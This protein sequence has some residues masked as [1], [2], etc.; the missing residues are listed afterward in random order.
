MANSEDILLVFPGQF[1]VK[2]V[3]LP[4]SLLYVAH[5]L[6]NAGYSVRILD[7]RVENYKNFTWKDF[8]FVGITTMSGRQVY[9]GLEVAKFIKGRNPRQ[10]IIWGGPH[11]TI[12]PNEVIQS[13]Y[14]DIV[15]RGEGEET[16]LALAGRLASGKTYEDI[17]GLTFMEDEKIVSTKDTT[18]VDLNK[19]K[20]LPYFLLDIKSYPNNVEK[21]DYISSKG[22][23]HQCTFCSDAANYG[24]SWRMKSAE[25]VLEEFEYIINTFRPNRINIQD[26][27]FFVS[28]KRVERIC[29]GIL[30]RGWKIELYSFI[31]ADY[32]STYK[33]DFL[34]LIR[35]AGFKE[36]AFGAESGSD[37]LLDFIKKRETGEQILGAVRK[38]KKHGIKPVISLMI[39][40]PT[41]TKK[42]LESTLDLYDKIMDIYPEAMVNGLFI[43]TPFP[44]SSLAEFVVKEYGYKFPATL[45]DWGK[46]KWSSPGNITW[47]EKE[48][49]ERYEAIYLLV[50]FLFVYKL[51]GNWTFKQLKARCGS[52]ILASLVFLFNNFFYPFAKIRWENR[53]FKHPFE[54]RLW[55]LAYGRFKGVD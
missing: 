55:Y 18:P 20:H 22:C 16:L 54:W 26:A 15:V 5:P 11:P 10:K 51:L 27:N 21:F 39:G 7:C 23:P 48:A 8:L 33:D 4:L 46:W 47:V 32:V 29:E 24:R 45:E 25:T 42:E 49:R 50:R 12:I 37:R 34:E 9:E 14:S 28:K 35:S 36:V 19:Y 53:I 1:G 43:F 3:N 38:L 52:Y 40:L 31:R 41:E 44:G 6:V 17:N 30:Q 13:S 2:D